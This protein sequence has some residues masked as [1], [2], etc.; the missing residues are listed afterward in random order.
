MIQI[1]QLKPRELVSNLLI[2]SVNL[3]VMH[4]ELLSKETKKVLS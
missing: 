2:S 1:C 3:L 4:V